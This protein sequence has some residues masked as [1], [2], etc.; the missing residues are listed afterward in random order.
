[1]CSA[2]N[3]GTSPNEYVGI[4]RFKGPN[5]DG[6]SNVGRNEQRHFVKTN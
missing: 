2:A 1:M 3:E 4:K 6:N 5:I